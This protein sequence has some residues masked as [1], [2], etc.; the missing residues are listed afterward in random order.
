MKY[1]KT[2]QIGSDNVEDLHSGKLKLQPGQWIKLGWCS[3]KA[4][5][6]GVTSSGSLWVSH[7]DGGHDQDHF[8]SLCRNISRKGA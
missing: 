8:R 2:I 7:W 3:H 5:W 4:R 1:V 6:V